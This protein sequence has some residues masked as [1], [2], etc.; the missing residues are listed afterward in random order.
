MKVAI[1][2][3]GIG[4]LTLALMLHERGIDVHV[5]EAVGEIRPLGVG[6]N[7]LPH[8]SQ[9][10]CR[11]G[12][13]S[14]LAAQGVETSTLAYFNKFGQEIWREPRGRAAGYD[15]PQYSI[16]RG[17]LQMSLLQAV[18]ERLGAD[19]IHC[20]HAFRSFEQVA[21]TVLSTFVRQAD[22]AEVQVESDVL[23]GADGIHS[24]V[25]RFMY[26]QGDQPRFSGRMLWRAVTQAEPF[27]D[28]RSMFMAGHQDQK[29]VCYPISEPLRK[30]GRSLLNWI[31][32]LRVP[33]GE[34]PKSDW[35]RKVDKAV[36]SKPFDSWKWGWIDIPALIDAAE[37][38][39]EFPLVDRD[40]LPRWTFERVTLMGDA[41]H[42]MYPI[43]S[44]GSAQAILDARY[45]ADCLSGED[46][47]LYALREYEAERLPRTTGIV[48]RNRMNG[49]EQVMQLA[50]QRAPDGFSDIADVVPRSELEAISLRYKRLA[51]FDK[52]TLV[53]AQR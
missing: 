18:Q 40:P 2:G 16:H 38:V 36:F 29:F 43:G 14:V 13:E 34:P 22:Q 12:L 48:L 50:E 6:I 39:Y 47:L 44:N 23:V 9:Q 25:R 26:P 28:G 4:G 53:Q 41:A 46:G 37:V 1:A 5:Y 31:A 11:L 21:D 49:P 24:A 8:A 27:M 30:Q 45:L 33:D 10:L 20:G 52:D 3:G 7:L 17:E 32:E 19:R 15:T 42:P 35:N 51:G